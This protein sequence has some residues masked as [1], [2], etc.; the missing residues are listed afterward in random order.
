ME[1][2]LRQEQTWDI[3]GVKE[4]SRALSTGEHLPISRKRGGAKVLAQR[5]RREWPSVPRIY[6]FRTFLERVLLDLAGLCREPG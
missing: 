5:P 4:N 6:C 2:V 3:V 1:L